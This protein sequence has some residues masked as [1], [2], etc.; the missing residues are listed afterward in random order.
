MPTLLLGIE[1][2]L[3]IDIIEAESKLLFLSKSST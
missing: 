1:L 2:P 3:G